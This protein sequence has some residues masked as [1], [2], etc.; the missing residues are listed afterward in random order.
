VK[1]AL[2]G[3]PYATGPASSLL[4]NTDNYELYVY[5]QA[6]YSLKS[7][8]YVLRKVRFNSTLSDA[9]ISWKMYVCGRTLYFYAHKPE[10]L[11]KWN[12]KSNRE[13]NK[14]EL[15]CL[16]LFISNAEMQQQSLL[17]FLLFWKQ[18]WGVKDVG[19]LI[20]QRVWNDRTKNLIFVCEKNEKK[21][22]RILKR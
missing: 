6:K 17:L 7:F 13:I 12:K 15:Q 2:L 14:F 11:N 8:P 9:E 20:A 18:N 10:D 19:R 16:D 4:V 3:N 22:I 1:A 21:E 5:F